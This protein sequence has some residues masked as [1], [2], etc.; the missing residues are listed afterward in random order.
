[1]K[2]SDLNVAGDKN[3]YLINLCKACNANVY[4]FGQMGKYYADRDLWQK[5]DIKIYFHEYNHPTYRQKFEN[6]EP[7]LS[8][9]DLLFNE[10]AENASRIVQK[11]N[12]NKEELL[13]FLQ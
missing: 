8:V 9:I 7:Y 2:A 10:G 12:I 4:V 11:G 5:N 13:K 1:M 6:F 3:Q